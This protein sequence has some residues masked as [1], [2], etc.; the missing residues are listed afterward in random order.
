[1]KDSGGDFSYTERLLQAHRDLVILIGDERGLAA[2][3]QR[4]GQGAISGLA[5]VYPTEL[6]ALIRD[7]RADPRIPLLV[8]EV[9]RHPVVPAV[10]ALIAH[11]T[12]DVAWLRVR[13]PLTAL[14]EPTAKRI[15]AAADAIFAARAA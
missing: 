10:K 11:R 4:G 13:S 5:N 14:D 6:A 9:L 2:G 7:G 8:D 12:N 1:M 15:G 3:V